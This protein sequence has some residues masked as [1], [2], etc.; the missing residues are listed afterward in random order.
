MLA[1]LWRM[2]ARPDG[3]LFARIKRTIDHGGVT[4]IR[5]TYSSRGVAIT[6]APRIDGLVQ[7]REPTIPLFIANR[8]NNQQ[9]PS[10]GR[11]DVCHTDSLSPLTQTFLCLVIAQLPRSAPQQTSGTQ[12]PLGINIPIR[13]ARG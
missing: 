3:R 12:V 8:R 13:I 6:I 5:T 2:H 1:L 11:G 10:A 4:E 9:I 7:R